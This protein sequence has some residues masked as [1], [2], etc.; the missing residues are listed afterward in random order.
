MG[1]S[2]NCS[3]ISSITDT[4]SFCISGSS[5]AKILVGEEGRRICSQARLIGG[6]RFKGTKGRRRGKP[7]PKVKPSMGK[8]RQQQQRQVKGGSQG[9]SRGPGGE[10]SGAATMGVSKSTVGASGGKAT[11][12]S[13]GGP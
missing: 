6:R 3:S 2:G 8:E 7:K 10:V 4:G 12:G 5:S 1:V 11:T 13:K 9:R